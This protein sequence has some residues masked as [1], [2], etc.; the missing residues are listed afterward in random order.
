MAII[1]P[2]SV[3]MIGAQLVYPLR[4]CLPAGGRYKSCARATQGVSC[5]QARNLPPAFASAASY[6]VVVGVLL[7]VVNE[8]TALVSLPHKAAA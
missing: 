8:E 7:S 3:M 5:A 4:N 2:Q 1:S 6:A